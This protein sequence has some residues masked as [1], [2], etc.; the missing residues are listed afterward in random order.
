MA[1]EP[2]HQAQYRHNLTVAQTVRDANING[3]DW[4]IT[5]KFYTAL[6]IVRAYLARNGLAGNYKYLAIKEH[7]QTLGAPS[8]VLRAF[9]RFLDL[10]SKYRYY[11]QWP[12]VL[13]NDAV[14]ADE[15]LATILDF[16][17]Q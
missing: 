4:V 11:C 9:S 7:L 15:Y 14:S 16:T 13:P 3:G 12:N 6:H 5:L 1:S 10:S 8:R 17:G 2:E